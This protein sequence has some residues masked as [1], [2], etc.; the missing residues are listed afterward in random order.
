MNKNDITGHLQEKNGYFY[1]VLNLRN[2]EGKWRPKWIKTGLKVKGNKTQ[3]NAMLKDTLREYCEKAKQESVNGGDILFSDYM[4]N[5]L[6]KMKSQLAVTTI[7]AYRSNI[8]RVIGPYFDELGVTLQELD[9]KH[10]TEFYDYLMEKR[11]VKAKTVKRYHANLRKALQRAYLNK[12][13]SSNIADRVELPVEQPFLH[14]YYT[15]DQLNALIPH[16]KGE[17]IELAALIT[18]FYGFRRSETMGLMWGAIDFRNNTISVRH[19]V[20]EAMDEDGKLII[21]KEDR[22][23]NKSSVRTLP[24]MPQIAE[25][26][27]AKQAEQRMYQNVCGNGYT[28]ENLAYV[29]VDELGELLKPD[30][31][32]RRFKLI[33]K[34]NNLPPIRFHDL[35]HS[36]VS[37][38]IAAGVSMKEIQAWVG[39]SSFNTTANIYE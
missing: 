24:L 39:H 21:V 26:L 3:A 13:I 32:S 36:C 37:L 9:V 34:K 8:N 7:S 28:K 25:L 14:S 12:E 19:I 2:G 20:T 10:L 17:R 31:I 33:L 27:R 15:V 18:A 35:R 38:L 23:K 5:W 1:M 6:K 11:G 30:Y 4:R 16:L 29:F 22:G